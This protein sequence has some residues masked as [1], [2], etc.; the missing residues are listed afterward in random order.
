MMILLNIIH[1]PKNSYRYLSHEDLWVTYHVQDF[2]IGRKRAMNK[3]EIT[4]PTW[5]NFYK[6]QYVPKKDKQGQGII[7]NFLT[8]KTIYTSCIAG[9]TSI[10]HA[11]LLVEMG[12]S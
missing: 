2:A 4:V 9:M 7:I 8:R 6:T 1:F 5:N 3:K 10:D 12:S 11:Q